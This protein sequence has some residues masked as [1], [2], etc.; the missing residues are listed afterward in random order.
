LLQCE[1]LPPKGLLVKFLRLHSLRCRLVASS[2]LLRVVAAVL[3]CL[4]RLARVPSRFF[5]LIRAQRERLPVFR[6]VWSL[7]AIMKV[8]RRD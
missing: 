6:V 2:D 3:H 5:S 7:Q 1:K 8:L 4:K